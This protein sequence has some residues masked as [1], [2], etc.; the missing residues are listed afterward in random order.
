[1]EDAL[2]FKDALPKNPLSF[3]DLIS[4]SF[5]VVLVAVTMVPTWRILRRIG[6]V[7]V[8]VAVFVCSDR[9]DCDLAGHRVPQM[10]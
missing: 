5:Y 6:L 1:V 9:D 2:K 7:A 4:L 8:V 10:A 3:P